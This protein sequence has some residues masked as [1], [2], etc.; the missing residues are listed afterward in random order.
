[1]T[2][3]QAFPVLNQQ[4]VVDKKYQFIREM[5]Q[6]AYGVVCAAKDSSTGEQVAIKKVCRIFE[7]TIL[8]KR[9]LR[10]V[11]LL[12]FFNG[13]ENITSVLDMDIVN[14]QDFNEIYL[15]QE[16]MEADLHQIIRSG[17]PLTDAHFQYFVYQICR[18]L[19]YIHSANVLHR[20]LKPGNLLVNAD[21]ELKICDFGL[22]R[23]YSDNA[24][25]NAGFMTEYVATRWY[26]APEIMLSFQSYTKANVD[27]LNQILGILGT[28]DEETLRRVGSE[29]AQ[30][31]IRSLP[32]MPRIPFENLY[33]RANPMAIDLLNKLL[34]FDPSKRITVEEALAHP[35]L[36]AYHDEDDEPTHSQ[37][38]DFSFEVVDAIED[39]SRMIAQEVMSYKASKQPSLP[40]NTGANLR[41]RESMS[42]QDREAL[43]A[44]QAR[45]TQEANDKDS[46]VS[47][48]AESAVHH[49]PIRD[50]EVDE[51][52]KELSGV[53]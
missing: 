52:E 48:V 26:R 8:A 1:M 49:R 20:D 39:M 43:S 50:M 28:P 36:S 5:G 24:D 42:A 22:A 18:G 23:G 46:G 41:R 21:C 27:Q 47:G 35:Y 4:F 51:L 10:E 37:T 12:K 44:A 7:K 16:L 33:P 45:A 15:V 31:Y 25:Y 6:G 9:A 13:H 14:L 29:R 38:F 30:V 40:V 32:R 17:Q 11:K 53:V 19:K 34:E 3:Y 2:G